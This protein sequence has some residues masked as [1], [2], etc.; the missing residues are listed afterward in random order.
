MLRIPGSRSWRV[1]LLLL[2]AAMPVVAAAAPVER[3]QSFH[4]DPGW[5]G[6]QNRLA[7]LEPRQV[8]QDFGYS[9]TAHAGGRPGEAGGFISPAAET[10]YY[11]W[12]L[13]APR[14]LETPLEAS[15]RVTL[16]G[17]QFH[18]LLGFFEAEPPARVPR[19]WRTPSS[20]ALRLQGRGDY[21]YAYLE[22]CTA[23]WRA[24]GD[25]PQGFQRRD[26]TTG[27][28]DNL[29]LPLR[30]P[31][32][33]SL[34]YDP[35]GNGGGGSLIAT[36]GPHRAVCNLDPGHKQDGA[37]FTRFGL[38]TVLKSADTGGEV[39]IDDVTVNGHREAFDR[40]PG[41]EGFGNRR[42]FQSGNVRP[43]FDFG[44]SP[45]RHAG[46]TARGEL[47]GN[48]FRGD[49]REAGRIGYYADRI[50]PLPV[51]GPLRASGRIAL[52]R[53]VSDSTSLLGYFNAAAQRRTSEDQSC[54]YPNPFVG[55]VIEGPSAEGFFLYPAWRAAGE[56]VDGARAVAPLRLLPDG[57]PHSWSMELLPQPDG[58]ALLRAT[59]DGHAVE[60]SVPAVRLRAGLA[61]PA[62]GTLD[63][64]GIVTTRIDGNAQ[65]LFFDDLTYTVAHRP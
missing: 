32:L 20:L 44:Y 47:G 60:V 22:Y 63:R 46:G 12:R 30:T 2:G 33:W 42:Q 9:P 8:R 64:F 15:G 31:M 55:V 17:P 54:T 36:L 26:P 40:D 56:Y 50:A 45:T 4:R 13:P 57:R 29:H 65:E 53:G 59:L 34:R 28:S 51:S 23:R 48:I 27:R 5:E 18:V 38:L 43:R 62:D 58:S 39:W 19:E 6:Y 3:Q 1:V 14:S 41:W 16:A 25:S 61:V 24:G 37:R 7:Q 10:A 21:A 11:A 35:R 52:R 49:G